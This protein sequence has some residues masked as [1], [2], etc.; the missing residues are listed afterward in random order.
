MLYEFLSAN[1]E[2]IIARTRAK[3]AN[4]PTPRDDYLCHAAKAQKKRSDGMPLAPLPK[5]QQVVVEDQF[6][7]RRYDLKKITKLCQPFDGPPP[8]LVQSL[9]PPALASSPRLSEP[10]RLP[11]T[12]A[13]STLARSAW[14]HEHAEVEVAKLA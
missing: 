12:F 13:F 4:R 7:T 14:N 3:V 10:I 8:S 2:E 1:R 11:D 9:M 5:G 6:Q